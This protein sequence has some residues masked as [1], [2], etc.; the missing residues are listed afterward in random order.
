VE[1]KNECINENAYKAAVG[2]V[3]QGL[4]GEREEF[5]MLEYNGRNYLFRTLF[6]YEKKIYNGISI[7]CYKD[8][9]CVEQAELMLVPKHYQTTLAECAQERYKSYAEQIAADSLTYKAV[10]EEEENMLG[11]SEEKLPGFGE[12]QCD[13][14]NDGV[15]D[16]YDVGRCGS[17]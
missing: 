13:L 11:S 15:V 7:T 10:F 9:K 5:V 4:P 8:G 16:K 14:N 17:G 2:Y 12:Y 6:D 1:E 3:G